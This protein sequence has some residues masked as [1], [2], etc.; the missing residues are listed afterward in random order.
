M[1]SKTQAEMG[2]QRTRDSI[3]APS[4]GKREEGGLRSALHRRENAGTHPNALI[5][6]DLLLVILIRIERV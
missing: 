2:V 5:E 6:F 1:R 3:I 4:N